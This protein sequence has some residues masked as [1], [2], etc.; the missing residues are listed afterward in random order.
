MSKQEV[1]KQTRNLERFYQLV[2]THLS[3]L[4]EEVRMEVEEVEP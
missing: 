4:L 2:W 1:L 3:V